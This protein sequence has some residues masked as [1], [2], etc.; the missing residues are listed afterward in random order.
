MKGL[1]LKLGTKLDSNH[2]IQK[3]PS[4]ACKIIKSSLFKNLLG[5]FEIK[6]SKFVVSGFYKTAL[7][8]YHIV[9]S[10]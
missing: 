1:N 7:L 2:K 4:F 10:Q 3:K 5:V 6:A 8:F 9:I